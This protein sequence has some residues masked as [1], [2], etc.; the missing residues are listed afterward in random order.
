ML[1]IITVSD[2]NSYMIPDSVLLV[3][4]I[5]IFTIY[6]IRYKTFA[7][8]YL[9]QGVFCFIFMFGFKLIGN[10]LL[11]KES[12]GDGDIKL[13]AVVGMVIG[14]KKVIFSLFLAAYLGLPYAIY[15]MVKK[16]VNH[17][18]PFG[19]FLAIASIIMLF[20][21]FDLSNLF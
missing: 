17:E 1:V 12:M 3:S 16:S 10:F 11:R 9:A 19:P 18:V 5:L 6:L 7:F 21:D 4:G 20:L 15:V 2:F 14:F 8:D 13:M